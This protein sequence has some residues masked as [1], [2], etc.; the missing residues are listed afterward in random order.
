MK[1]YP[2]LTAFNCDLSL[3]N[4]SPAC[5]HII[6]AQVVLVSILKAK[7]KKINLISVSQ[8]TPL[9]EA[10]HPAK[11]FPVTN[12]ACL[13][14]NRNQNIQI[15]KKEYLGLG[16]GIQKHRKQS[17]ET[18]RGRSR[19]RRQVNL[20][21]MSCSRL[22]VFLHSTVT[23]GVNAGLLNKL[24]CWLLLRKPSLT[25]GAGRREQFAGARIQICEISVTREKARRFSKWQEIAK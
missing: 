11:A 9:N 19:A 12:R 18:R 20:R 22:D 21:D 10:T 15:D 4:S 2:E 17:T 16:T 6:K 23:A 7:K 14:L 13:M 3:S 1:A 5:F 8:E 25:A 24:L